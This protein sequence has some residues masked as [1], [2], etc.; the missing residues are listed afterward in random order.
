MDKYELGQSDIGTITHEINEIRLDLQLKRNNHYNDVI[1]C[2]YVYDFCKHP[3]ENAKVVFYNKCNK[4]IGF[5]YTSC[6]GLYV[7]FGVKLN[8]VIRITVNKKGYYKYCSGMMCI[9]TKMFKYNMCLQK[10][11]FCSKALISGHIK[12][13]NCNPIK[14][15]PVY[16]LKVCDWCCNKSIF[17]V[18]NS[19]EYGQF[20]FY[21]LRRGNYIVYIDN[22]KFEQYTKQ[23]DITETDR[24]IDVDVE[25]IK[26]QLK[27]NMCGYIKDDFGRAIK[28]AVVI[29]YRVE[30]NDKLIPIEYTISDDNGWYSFDELPCGKYVAKAI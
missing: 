14:N 21:D 25:L 3:I 11:C 6:E 1:I 16:L 20:V 22:P 26:R 27:T 24:I 17:R 12:D 28:K 15:I 30:L 10:K 23:I 13:E 18:T 8:S 19:N 4:E 7:F 5:V 2:G 9:Y 29:L